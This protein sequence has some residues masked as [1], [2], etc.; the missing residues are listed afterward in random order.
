MVRNQI[1][2]PLASGAI[3]VCTVLQKVLFN[4]ILKVLTST[5]GK[6][7]KRKKGKEKHKD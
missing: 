6:K 1:P 4:I 5:V 3:Q 7:I 2:Y